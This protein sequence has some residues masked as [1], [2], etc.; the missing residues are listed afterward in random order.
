MVCVSLHILLDS[1]TGHDAVYT[2]LWT[3]ELYIRVAARMD[4]VPQMCVCEVQDRSCM[5]TALSARVTSTNRRNLDERLVAVYPF[6]LPLSCYR[7]SVHH[8]RR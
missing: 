7:I 6:E 4:R 3:A 8:S 1:H 2:V 5:S